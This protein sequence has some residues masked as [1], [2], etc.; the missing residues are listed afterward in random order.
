MS[1]CGEWQTPNNER[2]IKITL[3]YFL[4]DWIWYVQAHVEKSLN[5]SQSLR[6]SNFWRKSCKPKKEQKTTNVTELN[7]DGRKVNRSD[8][9]VVQVL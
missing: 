5:L 6:R 7:N 1:V 4:S 8:K 3:K 2:E 9:F